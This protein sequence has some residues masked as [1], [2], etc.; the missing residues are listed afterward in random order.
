[1]SFVEGAHPSMLENMEPRTVVMETPP[2]SPRP[3]R[4]NR[5]TVLHERSLQV[6]PPRMAAD[7]SGFETRGK[8]TEMQTL[9]MITLGA[10]RTK[11]L[12]V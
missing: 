2:K 8:E 11:A 7:R 3:L 12:S 5:L 10:A 1:M 4:R 9:N 6:T